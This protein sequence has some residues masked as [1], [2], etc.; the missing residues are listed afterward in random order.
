MQSYYRRSHRFPVVAFLDIKS[1]YDTVDRRV[2]WDALSQSGAASSPLLPLLVHL[3]DDVSISILISNHS[4]L[5]FSPVTGVLQGSVLSPH[6]YSVYINTLP[7]L[8]R[9]VAAP[10]TQMVPSS[11]SPDAGMVPV[12]SLLFADD[13]AVFGSARSV[14]QMLRLAEQHSFS[15]GYRWNPMK[16]AVLN[17]SPSSNE[18]H[19]QLYGTPLPLVSDFTYLGMPFVKTGLSAAMV[20]SLRSPGVLKLMGILNMIGVNRQGFSL[21]LCARI[22]STFVRPKF[23]YGLAISKFSAAQAKTIDQLQDKCLRMMVGGHATSST[24]VIKHMTTLPSMFHRI[25]VLTTRF[26][27][28]AKTL[29]RSCLLSLLTSTLPSTRLFIH[30]TKNPL[31]LALPSPLP[32]SNNQLKSFFHGYRSYTRMSP[33]SGG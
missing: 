6:L 15:L 19:I 31:F 8:L 23:E 16:C 28:R 27:L 13:V 25:D 33:C 29:P 14:Q 10:A 5:P 18:D 9:Q 24:S 30:L 2:I 22:Y 7:S 11:G 26:C 4:S 21:L 1:A 32:A 17:H 12:N 3:F 20:L